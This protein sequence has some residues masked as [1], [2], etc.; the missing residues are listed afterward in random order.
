GFTDLQDDRSLPG[1]EW[2]FLV[3]REAAARFGTDVSSVGSAVQLVTT[4]LMLA[5]YRPEDASDEVDIRVRL[6]VQAR[7]LDQLQRMTLQTPQGQ[8]PPS[9]FATLEPAEK[10]ST[11]RRLDGRRTLTL[12]ADLQEGYQLD[13]R[14]SLLRP[15]LSELPQG[16]SVKI[17]GEDADMQEAAQFLV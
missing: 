1:I 15:Y 16:V 8:S 9:N 14:L 3:N 5:T 2:R 6:P 11:L 12:Q 4:G 7:T 17:A 13:E 10:T